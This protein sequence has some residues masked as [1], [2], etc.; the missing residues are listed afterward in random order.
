[1][2]WLKSEEKK[3]L[4][5][6]KKGLEKNS[7]PFELK[8][9]SKLAVMVVFLGVLAFINRSLADEIIECPHCYTEIYLESPVA[10]EVPWAGC[11]CD[12]CDNFYV[13][14]NKCPRC[15]YPRKK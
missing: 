15:G 9:I 12:K 14:G 1:M 13:H 5:D 2:S 8:I 3:I 7:K 4:S 10:R 11:Y 6:V